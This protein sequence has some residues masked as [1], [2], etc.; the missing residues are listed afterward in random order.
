MN[1]IG[2]RNVKRPDELICEEK[3]TCC[4]TGRRPEKLS[5]PEEEVREWL[6]ERIREI[7]FGVR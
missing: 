3:N 7:C 5:R 2:E 1:H 4:F 6:D